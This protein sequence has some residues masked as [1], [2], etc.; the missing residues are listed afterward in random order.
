MRET[1]PLLSILSTTTLIQTKEPTLELLHS[2]LRQLKVF[3]ALVYVCYVISKIFFYYFS[4]HPTYLYY[5]HIVVHFLCIFPGYYEIVEY[6]LSRGADVDPLSQDGESP[7]FCAV[8]HGHERIVTLLLKHGADVISSCFPDPLLFSDNIIC[9]ALLCSFS[10]ILYV[11][12]S[13]Q[14]LWEQ[15]KHLFMGELRLA[16][17]VFSVRLLP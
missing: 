3:S 4:F 16:A 5:F 15:S 7:L 9:V 11:F 8:F 17:F 2:T 6:L 12:S 14:Y 1:K 13:V 10:T